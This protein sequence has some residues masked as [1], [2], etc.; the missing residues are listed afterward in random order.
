VI[1]STNL[2]ATKGCVQ[3]TICK[4]HLH[5]N[6][7]YIVTKTFIRQWEDITHNKHKIGLGYDK[8]ILNVSFHIQYFSKP[9]RLWSVEFLY[10]VVPE[11]VDRC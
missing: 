11:H 3:E 1:S 9:I 7:K 6:V 2:G 10:G 4:S 5:T 8:D